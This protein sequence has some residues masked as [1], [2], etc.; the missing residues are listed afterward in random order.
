[1]TDLLIASAIVAGIAA[2]CVLTVW[3]ALGIDRVEQHRAAE[4][5][6]MIGREQRRIIRELE[7]NHNDESETP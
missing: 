7:R 1:M 4:D 6:H 5:H 2:G 3:L